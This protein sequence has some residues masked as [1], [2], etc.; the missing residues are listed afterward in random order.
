V[1]ISSRDGNSVT[2]R[3]NNGAGSFPASVV[4]PVG[5]E[6]RNVVAADLDRDGLPDLATSNHDS[7]DLSVLIN[8]GGGTFAPHVTYPVGSSVRPEWV[9]AADTDGDGDLELVAAIGENPGRVAVLANNGAGVFS[10]PVNFSAGADPGAVFAADFDGDRHLDLATANETGSNATILRNSGTGTFSLAATL[11]TG[12]YSEALAAGDLDGD[13]DLDLVV[14]NRDANSVSVLLN[15]TA[16]AATGPTMRLGGR[17]L[18]GT[19]VPLQ[20]S[21]PTERALDYV[22]LFSHATTPAIR[23][24]DGRDL[25]LA[26]SPILTL[27]FE[28]ALFRNGIGTL[29]GTGTSYVRFAIPNDAALRNVT[30]YGAFVVL[31]PRRPIGIGGISN[32]LAITLE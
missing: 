12:L 5:A 28:P 9:T 17:P 4:L 14:S 23:L 30:V 26:F 31:D 8:R 32:P 11:P 7:R 6:P 27:S 25:P 19:T 3:W 20:D 16:G 15:Q 22:T 10:G 13:G 21:S 18:L 29:D 24:P 1:A 2:V